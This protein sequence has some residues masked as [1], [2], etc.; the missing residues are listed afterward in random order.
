MAI[1]LQIS[2][3][4]GDA[5]EASFKG[6]FN[7]TS[8]GWNESIVSGKMKSESLTAGYNFATNRKF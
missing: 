4:S 8:M 6:W 5:T 7:L 1:Y 3:L 2:G